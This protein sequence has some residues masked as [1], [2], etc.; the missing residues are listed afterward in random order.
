MEILKLK[1]R[2]TEMKGLIDTFELMEERISKFENTLIEIIQSEEINRMKIQAEGKNRIK[3][4]EVSEKYG[5]SLSTLLRQKKREREKN[6]FEE[7]MAENVSN[8]L[9]NITLHIQEA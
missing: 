9:K 4:N 1:S 3:K 8:M 2:I 5:T 7:I 6:I